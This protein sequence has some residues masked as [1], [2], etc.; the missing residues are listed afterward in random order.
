[1]PLCLPAHIVA[2]VTLLCVLLP[3]SAYGQIYKWIDADGKVHYSDQK[4]PD[5]AQNPPGT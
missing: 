3:A 4:P 2:L 5:N 1:M